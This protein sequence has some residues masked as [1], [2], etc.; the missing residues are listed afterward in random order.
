MSKILCKNNIYII[1]KIL[2][3]VLYYFF[4]YICQRFLNKFK[5]FVDE[6]YL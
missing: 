5:N 3:Y 4:I 1:I 6:K 2:N